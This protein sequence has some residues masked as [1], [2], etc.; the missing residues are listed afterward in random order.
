MIRKYVLPLLALVGIVFAIVRVMI[1]AKPVPEA[2]PVTQP[3]RAPYAAYVAGAG[4]VEASSENIAIGTPIGQVVTDVYAKVGDR[5]KAGTPLFKLRDDTTQADLHA[6]KAALVAAQAKLQRLKSLPR[7]EDVPPAEAKVHEAE[8]SLADV[9][10]QLSLYESVQDKRAVSQDELERRRYAV[11]L[12]DARLATAK[13]E[14]DLLKAGSWD[15]DLLIAQ[16]DVASAQAAVKQTEVY[17]E[18]H[19]VRAPM[20]AQVLQVKIRVGEYAQTG[21]LATPLMLLGDVDKLYVRVDVDENDAW[22]VRAELPAVAFVRGNAQL[23]TSLT[24]VRIEPYV[25]PK[26][27][28]TGD[29]TERV[30]TRVLQ[31]IYSFSRGALPVYVGQQMDVFIESPPVANTVVVSP[32]T[33]AGNEGGLQ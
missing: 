16:A 2:A 33:R 28:L 26:R 5:V 10:Q 22:R 6:K 7:P 24:F 1:G 21:P 14:L 12:A 19:T 32:A 9:K 15:K 4:I 23:K 3:A 11:R 31:V 18:Q 20:D 8:A 17:L 27:S 30:D 25:V 29:S 13:A